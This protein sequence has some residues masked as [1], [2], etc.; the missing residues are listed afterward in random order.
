MSI[1]WHSLHTVESYSKLIQF[2]HIPLFSPSCCTNMF[3]TAPALLLRFT[4]FCVAIFIGNLPKTRYLLLA[5]YRYFRVILDSVIFL[6][7]WWQPWRSNRTQKNGAQLDK[8]L[9]VVVLWS[10]L[11]GAP[12]KEDARAPLPGRDGTSWLDPHSAQWA[13]PAQPSGW[14]ETVIADINDDCTGRVDPCQHH[15][16]AQEVGGG[17]DCGDDCLLHPWQLLSCCIQAHSCGLPVINHRHIL[18][19]SLP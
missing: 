3:F 8:L 2:C 15:G 9:G 1:K 7:P 10:P 6:R 16:G 18:S 14:R 19:L 4:F 11:Q 5:F 17:K 13:T 12:T